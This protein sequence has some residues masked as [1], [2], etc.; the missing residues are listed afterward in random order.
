M[1]NVHMNEAERPSNE[2]EGRRS[3]VMAPNEDE[4]PAQGR[5]DGNGDEFGDWN[6]DEN[7]DEDEHNE[8]PPASP[9]ALG[10][11]DDSDEDDTELPQLPQLKCFRCDMVLSRQQCGAERQLPLRGNFIDYEH[12]NF[13]RNVLPYIP[14]KL[15]KHCVI[16]HN[17]EELPACCF[18][19]KI[20][21]TQRALE[22]FND[23]LAGLGRE[24]K[25]PA[26]EKYVIGKP[27]MQFD[28]RVERRTAHTVKQSMAFWTDQFRRYFTDT[29]YIRAPVVMPT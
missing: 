20:A 25:L 8:G 22:A 16:R 27:D 5:D 7:G 4:A 29:R 26:F 18:I 1:G 21:G 14:V 2:D 6:G 15:R 9:P 23:K 10:Q 28:Q 3:A 12:A 24:V 11:D 19:R 17:S 13:D